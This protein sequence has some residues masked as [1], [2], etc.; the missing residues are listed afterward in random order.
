MSYNAEDYRRLYNAPITPFEE[1]SFEIDYEQYEEFLT[2]HLDNDR[3]VEHGGLIVNPE[4]GEVFY[5]DDEEYE[6]TTEFALDVIG[7]EVPTFAGVVGLRRETV[8][9]RARLVRDLGADGIFL[10]PPM[11]S[12]EVVTAG[13]SQAYPEAWVDH[14]RSV[15]EV[16]DLPIIMH[17]T[18]PLSG[19]Y[20][21]G[22][23]REPTMAVL[24]EVENV[25]GWK[26]TYN[27]GGYNEVAEAI[28][29]LD[30]N[31]NVMCA[32]GSYY[33]EKLA[34]GYFDGSVSGSFNYALEPMLDHYLAWKEGDIAEATRI[35]EDGL[36]DL[37]SFIYAENK[38]KLHPRYKVAAWLRGFTAHP[39]MRPPMP[40][41]SMAEVERIDE[42]LTEVGLDTISKD[43]QKHVMNDPVRKL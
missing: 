35:W 13:G 32:S 29:G 3:F 19:Q 20:G 23:P 17:P 11:G 25:V 21:A 40:A 24:E 41:P 5:M 22:L 2:Y 1:G 10:M 34:A 31:V 9:E 30:R 42:L 28:Q 27:L 37:H 43:E 7:D 12:L 8:L 39:F 38:T 4:A 6:R 16:S 15:A 26:M 36:A 18:A 14:V 33:Q